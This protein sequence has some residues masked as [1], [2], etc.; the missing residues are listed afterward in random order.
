MQH[1]SRAI[2]IYSILLPY[3]QPNFFSSESGASEEIHHLARISTS[4]SPDRQQCNACVGRDISLGPAL[5]C[6]ALP[7][8]RIQS[9][10][11]KQVWTGLSE[12]SACSSS[13]PSCSAQ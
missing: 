1:Q 4:S 6:P 7:V 13:C 12:L 10:A 5:P 3:P 2:I 11:A 9:R 8:P